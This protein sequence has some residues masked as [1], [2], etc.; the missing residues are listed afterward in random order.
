MQEHKKMHRKIIMLVMIILGTQVLLNAEKKDFPY[1]FNK[2]DYYI[3]P[4]ATALSFS[5]DIVM[6]ETDFD[7]TVS[8][9]E[10]LDRSDVNP[11]DRPATRNWDRNLDDASD[12]FSSTFPILPAA[13]IIPQIYKKQWRNTA[14]YASM[15][16][17]T[18]YLT[19]GITVL[20]KAMT[21]RT[22]PYLYNNSFSPEERFNFQ[23]DEAPEAK[24]S[25]FSGHTSGAFAAAVFFSKTYTDIYGNN[26]WSKVIWTTSLSA[27]AFT[28]YC[29]VEAGEHFTS[30]VIVGA[31]VGGA[32]G[33]IV[34]E[35][36]KKKYNNVS[37][38]VMPNYFGVSYKF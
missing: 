6:N 37:L 9:I 32:I 12:F 34:P 5:G 31:V 23:G 35:L 7:L 30:D 15:Y 10:K 13:I 19:K 25:F 26:T 33:Y 21:Q 24:S 36:H 20:T 8:E 2:K 29:R 3:F 14:V 22:R 18:Y 28:G 1:E 11:F 4:L 38:S 16:L 17:E 27:A